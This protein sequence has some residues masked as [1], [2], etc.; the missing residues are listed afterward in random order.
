M[1]ERLIKVLTVFRLGKLIRWRKLD[2]HQ[3]KIYDVQ[4][5]EGRFIVKEYSEDAIPDT[6]ALNVRR[7]Q[8]RVSREWN[9]N[10]VKCIL[11]RTDFLESDGHFYL[12]YDYFDGKTKRRL[13]Q[14]ELAIL[15]RTQAKIHQM[16]IKTSLVCEYDEFDFGKKMRTLKGLVQANNDGLA[17]A[18]RELVVSHNDYKPGNILWKDG[19]M[20]LADFDAM[21]LVNPTCA[22]YESAL[23]FS[24]A[25]GKIQRKKFDAY[26]E[27]YAKYA[28]LSEDARIL[29]VAANGKMRWLRF[30]LSKDW[31]HNAKIRKD[32]KNL[33]KE[34]KSYYKTIVRS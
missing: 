28:P 18:Q 13:K 29:A 22:A 12:V 32:I 2:S 8:I 7:E 23:T 26:L 30:L 33:T 25:H 17:A 10:G 19:E 14:K 27:E 11:P 1:K 15:A 16:K 21:S 24:L 20:Y 31:K 34:L 6:R 3:N 4:T 5:T 9:K